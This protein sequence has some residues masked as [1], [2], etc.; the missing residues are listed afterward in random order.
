MFCIIVH[1]MC[2]NTVFLLSCIV[3]YNC[4]LAVWQHSHFSYCLV[5]FCITVH[6]M[7]SNTLIFLIFLYCSI[8]LCTCGVTTLSFPIVLYCSVLLCGNTHSFLIVLNQNIPNAWNGL[9]YLW[10]GIK[11]VAIQPWY[12]L[13]QIW[14]Q[15]FSSLCS[16][17]GETNCCPLEWICNIYFKPKLNAVMKVSLTICLHCHSQ[18]FQMIY[19]ATLT[20]WAS[21][22]CD[23]LYTRPTNKQTRH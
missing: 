4:T 17:C 16:D 19:I 18:Q 14:S 6:L 1:L 7:C 20:M 9:L 12:N 8:L 23:L 21:L 13:C 10:V 15:L 3:L 2:G 5:L 22:A 11:L